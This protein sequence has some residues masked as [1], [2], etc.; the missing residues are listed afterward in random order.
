MF[1]LA[2]TAFMSIKHIIITMGI[3]LIV[4]LGYLGYRLL[5]MRRQI[6]EINSVKEKLNDEIQERLLAESRAMKFADIIKYSDDAIIGKDING[7]ITSWNYGAEVIYG[8]RKEEVI[9]KYISILYTEDRECEINEITEKIKS[10]NK[11]KNLKAKRKRKDDSEIYVSLTVSPVKDG[12]GEIIGT[13]SISRDITYHMESELKIQESYE[14]LSAVYSQLAAADEELRAQYDELLDR[15]KEL[16]N[17]E[18]RYKLALEVTND[19]ILEWDINTDRYFVSDRWHTILNCDNSYNESFVEYLKKIVHKDDMKTIL[20]AYFK[21]IKDREEIFKSEFRLRTSDGVYKWTYFKGK[22]IKDNE[23]KPF[24]FIGSLTDISERMEFQEK[25]RFLANYDTLTN[26]PNKALFFNTLDR[27]LKNSNENNTKGAVIAIDLDEFKIINDTLG[28]AVGDKVLI[29]VANILR[30]VTNNDYLISRTGGDEY[31]IL[32]NKFE[33]INEITSICRNL[34]EVMKKPLSI[35]DKEIYTRLSIGIAVFPDNGCDRETIF[36]NVDTA[37]YASKR[38]GRNR[39]TFFDKD[40]GDNIIRRDK[41][42]KGLRE[43]LENDGLHLVYQPKI[44]INNNKIAGFEALLR[45]HSEELG[46]VSPLEFIDVAE[47][48]GLI[49][50]IGNWVIEKAT[51]QNNDWKKRGFEYGSISVNVSPKQIQGENF[52]EE[53]EKIITDCEVCPTLLEVEITENSLMKEFDNNVKVL[54]QLRER[55]I[56]ISLDDFGTG[57]SS[58]SYLKEL[59]IN[60]L[61]IDKSFIDDIEHDLNKK[62]IVDGIIQL[63]HKINLDVVAEG[64]ENEEQ[65]IILKELNCDIIQ[66]YF[67][68]KPISPEE[69]ESKY[70]NGDL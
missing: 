53:V 62:A 34:G 23:G 29:E 60:I 41:I 47:E 40:L 6:E 37:L 26:L 28:H 43:A 39:Y 56:N 66:G 65:L 36:K 7:Y 3:L 31:V 11:V 19:G 24:K 21:H 14:E 17:S 68:S 58:L 59:P 33:D 30:K 44:D 25:I 2:V 32:I 18:E 46:F 22:M 70:F 57:Y 55:R 67:F 64:V 61:K 42:E 50:K 38:G 69:V 27:E 49:C 15:E 1:G 12:T 51:K 4:I 48:R 20:R 5:S 9:G 13:S 16:R 54:K 10:G 52:I 45:W 35:E 8:W 63:A